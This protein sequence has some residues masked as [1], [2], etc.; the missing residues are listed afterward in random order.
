[1]AQRSSG[2]AAP[3]PLYTSMLNYRYSGGANQSQEAGEPA[4]GV[5]GIRAEERTNYPVGVSVDDLG[6]DFS[7]EAQVVAPA[8]AERVCRIMHTAL[9]RLVE[10]L[11][12]SPAPAIR[13]IDVMPEAARALGPEAWTRT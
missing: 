1:L 7:L 10:A 4:E 12:V 6:E 8:D 5:R 13:S 11:D 9:E 3:A 2:V